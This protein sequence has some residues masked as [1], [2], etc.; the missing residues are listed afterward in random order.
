MVLTDAAGSIAPASGSSSLLTQCPTGAPTDEPT[1]YPTPN[2]TRY[3]TPNPTRY[4]T[5]A[6][7]KA[8]TRAPTM[9]ECVPGSEY[10]CAPGTA[11]SDR[12]C[13]ALAVCDGAAAYQRNHPL[14]S[15][16][17]DRLCAAV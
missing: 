5:P 3:P 10:E 7:T 11:T 15:T 2:P 9:T 17:E 14:T 6:P 16:T 4:P 8:P 12:R 1:Q 13:C